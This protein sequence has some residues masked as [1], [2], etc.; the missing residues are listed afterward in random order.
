MLRAGISKRA[1]VRQLNCHH[2]TISRLDR[3]LQATGTAS[4]RPRSGQ[5]RVTTRKQDATIRGLHT[6]FRFGAATTTARGM[7]KRHG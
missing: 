1:V 4:D 5:P 7:R 2:S 6:S 3:P